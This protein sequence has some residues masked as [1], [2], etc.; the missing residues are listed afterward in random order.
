MFI[1][2]ICIYIYTIIYCC[3]ICAAKFG[4]SLNIHSKGTSEIITGHPFK[5]M[6]SWCLWKE[7]ETV[8]IFWYGRLKDIANQK[9]QGAGVCMLQ[10][11]KKKGEKCVCVCVCVCV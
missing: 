4:N 9:N 2:H 10:C 8:F 5:R 7:N 6:L 11:V 3:V 1:T